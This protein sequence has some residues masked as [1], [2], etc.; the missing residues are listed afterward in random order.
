MGEE[1]VREATSRRH[2][3]YDVE[4]V[5]GT[6]LF[7]LDVDVQNMS[8]AGMA[9]KTTRALNVGRRYLFSISK[10]DEVVKVAGRVAWCVLGS[11]RKTEAGDSIPV[12][13]AGVQ[14]LDMLSAE[15]EGILHLI[16]ENA[17]LDLEQRVFGRFRLDSDAEVTVDAGVEFE[18][19]KISMSG[20]LAVLDGQ[21][22]KIGE[23]EAVFPLEIPFPQG[24]FIARGRVAYLNQVQV[25]GETRKEVHLGVEFQ[26]IDEASRQ[27]LEAFIAS[28]VV[29]ETGNGIAD[30]S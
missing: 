18:I 13:N 24:T 15:A 11:S 6:F 8:V 22:G 20:M 26:D 2:A 9:V 3:R 1:P 21:T 27:A 4:G 28:V 29:S 23:M 17:I 5:E 12:Y 14:F 30:P 16:E 19:R 7:N 10:S 25:R